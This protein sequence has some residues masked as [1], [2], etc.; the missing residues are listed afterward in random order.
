MSIVE[1]RLENVLMVFCHKCGTENGEESLYCHKCGTKLENNILGTEIKTEPKKSVQ[2]LHDT[3]QY[4]EMDQT[5]KKSSV[6]IQL[7]LFI[8]FIGV[9]AL[10]VP[11]LGIIIIIGGAALFY[12]GYRM[13]QTAKKWKKEHQIE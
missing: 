5:L 2:N 4:L 9:C 12:N 13:R 11:P 3:A 7:G 1:K 10:M 8:M 6:K